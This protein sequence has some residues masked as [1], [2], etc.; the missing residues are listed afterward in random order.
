MEEEEEKKKEEVRRWGGGVGGG[1]KW[2]TSNISGRWEF[3]DNPIYKSEFTC[4]TL[5]H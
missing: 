5:Q 1:E 2:K 3:M 4:I